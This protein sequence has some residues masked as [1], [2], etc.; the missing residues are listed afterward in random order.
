MS[1]KSGSHPR[2]DWP[3][4]PPPPPPPP[5]NQRQ[6]S[7]PSRVITVS[8]HC[9]VVAASQFGKVREPEVRDIDHVI[10][11]RPPVEKFH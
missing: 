1:V 11:K 3:L 10:R 8:H 9:R 5:T 6:V 4:V 7:S 2:A